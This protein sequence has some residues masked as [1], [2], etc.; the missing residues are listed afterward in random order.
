[1]VHSVVLLRD[2]RAIHAGVNIVHINSELHM[3]WKHGLEAG[4]APRED[5]VAPYKILPS[6]VA[7]IHGVV[8]ARASIIRRAELKVPFDF[9]HRARCSSPYASTPSRRVSALTT[10]LSP[11]KSSKRIQKP[12]HRISPVGR[13]LLA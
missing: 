9:G 4:L 12:S 10:Y 6:A 11:P 13:E 1:M 2:T 3:V 5:E 7:A 8:S